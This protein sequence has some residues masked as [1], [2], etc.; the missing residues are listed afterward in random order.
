M[1][2][3]IFSLSLP[4]IGLLL[5]IVGFVIVFIFGG[6]Q[7]GVSF[8]ISEE[9]SWYVLPARCVGALLVIIGFSLQFIGSFH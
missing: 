4:Q 9:H 6:F 2:E 3:S 7:F 8:Y 5:D 1:L